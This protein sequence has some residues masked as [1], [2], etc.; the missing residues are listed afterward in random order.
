MNPRPSGYETDTTQSRDLGL[1]PFRQLRPEDLVPTDRHCVPT[2]RII[3]T[4]DVV[5]QTPPPILGHD[6]YVH[7][8]ACVAFT[9]NYGSLAGNHNATDAYF[10]ALTHPNAPKKSTD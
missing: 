6:V 7:V 5:P 10:Y 3:N 9:A 4:S 8:G 1:H 2:F